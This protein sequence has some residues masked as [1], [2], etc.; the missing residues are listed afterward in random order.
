MRGSTENRID[1][2]GVSCPMKGLNRNDQ[3]GLTL[4]EL[5]AVIVILGILAAIA[6]PRFIGLIENA[7]VDADQA[8]V[9]TL[10]SVTSLARMNHSGPDPFLD[11]DQSDEELILFLDN[12]GYLASEPKPQS[13]NALFSWLQE[14]ERWHLLIGE[15]FFTV[16]LVDGLRFGTSDWSSNFISGEYIGSAKNIVFP[17]EVEGRTITRIWQDVFN[18]KGLMSVSFAGDSQI[19]H[20]HA[21]AFQDNN[22]SQIDFPDTLERIDLRSFRNNNL[23]ELRFPESLRTIE[24]NAFA[25]N[26]INSI[27]IGSGVT[28]GDQAFG[29]TTANFNSVYDG[30]GTY[31]LIDDEWIKQ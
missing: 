17:S 20:I 13:R 19:E 31:N 3:R 23:T 15:Y 2:N 26:E 25:G 24:Q 27:T 16:S 9:R 29:E 28:I 10:N 7:R 21:R 12:E 22:L 1:Q 6:V 11:D 14:D 18:G 30:A 4:I 8:T 5:L